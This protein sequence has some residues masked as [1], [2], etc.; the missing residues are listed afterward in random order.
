MVLTE[1][2]WDSKG[3]QDL[4]LQ[5]INLSSHLCSHCL[6]YVCSLFQPGEELFIHPLRG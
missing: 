4:F 1:D 2:G 5:L 6:A 3:L